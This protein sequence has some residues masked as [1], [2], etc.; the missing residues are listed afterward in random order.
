MLRLRK[1]EGEVVNKLNSKHDF[2]LGPTLQPLPVALNTVLILTH[3]L[4]FCCFSSL[5]GVAGPYAPILTFYIR[6][7]S[8]S[9]F[10]CSLVPVL[11]G[12]AGLTTL[13]AS[14]LIEKFREDRW[15]AIIFMITASLAGLTAGVMP[16]L[17]HKQGNLGLIGLMSTMFLANAMCNVCMIAKLAW[18]PDLV[19]ENMVGKVFAVDGLAGALAAG[20]AQPI[21]GK[22]L[23]AS[24][25]AG[26]PV[27]FLVGAAFGVASVIPFIFARGVRRPHP[28]HEP[29]L[30]GTLQLLTNRIILFALL[31]ILIVD[32]SSMFTGAFLNVFFNET[33]GLNYQT[34]GIVF[35][36][37]GIACAAAKPAWG[38]V[39]DG[40]G[41]RVIVLV[42]TVGIAL[43]AIMLSLCTIEHKELVYPA[44]ILGGILTAGYM[45]GWLLLTYAVTPAHKRATVL[46][47]VFICS[48]IGG[49]I[50][51]LLGGAVVGAIGDFTFEIAGRTFGA[52]NILLFLQACIALT[53]LPICLSLRLSR[54]TPPGHA[55]ILFAQNPLRALW[56]ATF[57]DHILRLVWS[58]RDKK[59]NHDAQRRSSEH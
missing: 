3:T 50:A 9:D 1:V 31:I 39:A 33:L 25:D 17:F 30:K 53:A 36:V 7:L 4:L 6:R 15:I 10:A 16:L 19:G 13:G 11:W 21:W 58:K 47:L 59:D 24:P 41:P 51:P 45:V 26:F 48:S 44:Q 23:D 35:L 34:V 22:Y 42:G 56:R 57:G 12:A 46:S 49:L 32:S 18:L 55:F 28:P 52:M 5:T 27:L 54:E 40:H 43:R 2:E 20:F 38:R 37:F 14:Y 8:D 29:F